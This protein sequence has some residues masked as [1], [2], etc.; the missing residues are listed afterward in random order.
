[1][2]QAWDIAALDDVLTDI[3]S[4]D[5]QLQ[6]HLPEGQL[7]QSLPDWQHAA[8]LSDGE[9]VNILADG[10]QNSNITRAMGLAPVN[11]PTVTSVVGQ[12]PANDSEFVVTHLI[13]TRYNHNAKTFDDRR[14][15]D[16]RGNDTTGIHRLI[17]QQPKDHRD[18]DRRQEERKTSDVRESNGHR[19]N[20][21]EINRGH[22][23]NTD[24]GDRRGPQLNRDAQ[25]VSRGTSFS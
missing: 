4:P 1:M 20:R 13:G 3:R 21:Q 15:N 5:E 8:T 25:M 11:A 6:H 18:T 23:G 9:V 14:V 2:Q 7:F 16:H 19:G 22:D 17:K 10:V 12:G 24:G